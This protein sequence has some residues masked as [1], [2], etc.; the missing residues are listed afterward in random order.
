MYKAL[1][2]FRLAR[3]NVIYNAKRKYSL[4]SG[5]S[6]S[7]FRANVSWKIKL[8]APT[9]TKKKFR[10]L[11]KPVWQVFI[12][13]QSA[14]ALLKAPENRTHVSLSSI[15]VISRHWGVHIYTEFYFILLELNNKKKLLFG[16][17]SV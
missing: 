13:D 1:F 5:Y 8:E 16:R 15:L 7:V 9:K 4:I 6:I 3:M 10:L 2:S 17:F 11:S 12:S 14:A